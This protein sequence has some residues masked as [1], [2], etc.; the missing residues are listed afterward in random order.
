M[1]ILFT[2][3]SYAC[4]WPLVF[5]DPFGDDQ[6]IIVTEIFSHLSYNY[7][8]NCNAV[9]RGARVFWLQSTT[10]KV[11]VESRNEGSVMYML[12]TLQSWPALPCLWFSISCLLVTVRKTWYMT[13]TSSPMLQW[14]WPF[15]TCTR[16]DWMMSNCTFIVPSTSLSLL[17][18]PLV[19]SLFLLFFFF[20]SSVVFF[21]WW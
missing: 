19:L 7:L 3:F 17:L 16:K 2:T 18:P 21:P 20:H 9:N 5:T 1:F 14:S 8:I 12:I 11:D 13:A 6:A 10:V 4:Q 15:S